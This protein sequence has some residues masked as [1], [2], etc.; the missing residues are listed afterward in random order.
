MYAKVAL[1]YTWNRFA[2]EPLLLFWPTADHHGDIDDV[3]AHDDVHDDVH[4]DIDDD[5][6]DNAGMM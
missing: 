3:D 1:T 5:E 2:R 4:V 6:N